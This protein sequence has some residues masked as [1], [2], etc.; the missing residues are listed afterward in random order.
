M[1]GADTLLPVWYVVDAL[2]EDHIRDTV[3]LVLDIPRDVVVTDVHRP[4]RFIR[5][6]FAA[7]VHQHAVR[8]IQNE[9]LGLHRTWIKGFCMKGAKVTRRRG[10][11]TERKPDPLTLVV[12]TAARHR[13]NELCGGTHILGQHFRI[14][15]KSP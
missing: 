4:R 13:S 1:I 8:K 12:V 14:S 5:K 15:L 2:V 7:A 11:E 3:R 6:A 10:P 9:R